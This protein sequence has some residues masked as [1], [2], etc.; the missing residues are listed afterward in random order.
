MAQGVSSRLSRPSVILG[1]PIKPEGL[2]RRSQVNGQSTKQVVR[3][4][5]QGGVHWVV[6]RGKEGGRQGGLAASLEVNIAG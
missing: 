2:R 3:T 6:E 4:A 1:D 5:T